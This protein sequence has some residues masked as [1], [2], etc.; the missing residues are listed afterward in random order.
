MRLNEPPLPLSKNV[1]VIIWLA[2]LAFILAACAS[3]EPGIE[4]SG[5]WTRPSTS[6]TSNAAFYMTIH[7]Q[8]S[9]SE[10]LTA[11][12]SPAC[13]EMQLHESS[14]DDQ[15]VMAMR[16]VSEIIIPSG[17]TVALQV[18]GLHLMCLDRQNDFEEDAEVSLSLFFEEA[19]QFDVTAIVK[20]Q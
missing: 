11:A 6:S 9:S 12:E 16:Q 20:D 7:N 15:G 19:G 5:A 3:D 17:G 4:V 2:A 18:G 14:I 1:L 8:G 10:S 13:G